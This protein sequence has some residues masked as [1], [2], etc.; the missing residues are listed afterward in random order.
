VRIPKLTT[1]ACLAALVGG[2]PALRSQQSEFGPYKFDLKVRLGFVG[3]DM[4][5]AKFDNKLLG[6]GIQARRE[7]FGPGS[8][9]ALEVQWEHVPSRW[10]DIA[11]YEKHNQYN[12]RNKDANGNVLATRDPNQTDWAEKGLLSLHPWWSFDARKETSRGFSLAVS[13]HQKMPSGTGIDAIDQ[14]LGGM[15]WFGGLRFDRYK[16]TSEFRWVLKD[17]SGQ[18]FIQPGMVPASPPLY[19]PNYPGAQ[20][21]FWQEA[22]ALTPGFF[23]GVRQTINDNF[24]FECGVRYFGTKHW[25]FT[26]GAYIKEADG[27][28][29]KEGLLKTGTSYGPAI[30]FALVC[31]L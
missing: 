2:A 3:G 25:D 13:Y 1:L 22:A 27:S 14:V 23:A 10:H 7:L 15:E 24:A 4:Q 30:E 8:A 16:T 31:K 19:T 18:A 28:H 12:N 20:G 21:A 9:V 29:A 17:Q 26:P 11:D 5:Q 6:F